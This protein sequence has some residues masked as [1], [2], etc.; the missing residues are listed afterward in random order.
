M[1]NPKAARESSMTYTQLG[2]LWL[3]MVPALPTS[4]G[5]PPSFLVA[6]T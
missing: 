4:P 1:L 6:V 2:L 3:E 5:E